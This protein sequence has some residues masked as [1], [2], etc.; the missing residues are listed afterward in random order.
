VEFK[1]SP[2]IFFIF[3]TTI[4][5]GCSKNKICCED[6]ETIK[7]KFIFAGGS[8]DLYLPYEINN[9]VE[10][11]FV[12]G[13]RFTIDFINITVDGKELPVSTD[14]SLRM[15]VNDPLVRYKLCKVKEKKEY[16]ISMLWSRK[17][18]EGIYWEDFTLGTSNHSRAYYIPRKS[19]RLH[20]TYRIILPYPTLTPKNL[21]DKDYEHKVYTNEYKICVDLEELFSSFSF[22]YS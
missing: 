2:I 20:I 16:H 8:W 11:V 18:T 7:G 4:F 14:L 3:I 21:F 22:K 1:I 5:C 17:G 10:Y 13:T 15:L 12:E 19:K 6:S 9:E